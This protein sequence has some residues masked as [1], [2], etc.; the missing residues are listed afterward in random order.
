MT[1]L[2]RIAEDVDAG[3]YKFILAP[4]G[5]DDDALWRKPGRSSQSAAGAE[6]AL[7]RKSKE[8][9]H[10]GKRGETWS[11]GGAV[12]TDYSISRRAA[13]GAGGDA[14][15]IHVGPEHSHIPL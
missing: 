5:G 4:L 15:S 2:A 11:I 1:I 6:G 13:R 3:V 10:K 7:A 14:A 12:F 8:S 9:I